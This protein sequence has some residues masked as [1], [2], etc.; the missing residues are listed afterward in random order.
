MMSAWSFMLLVCGII[1]VLMILMIVTFRKRE[2]FVDNRLIKSSAPSVIVKYSLKKKSRGVFAKRNFKEGDIIESAPVIELDT[3]IATHLDKL[4]DYVF[5]HSTKEKT[6]LVVFGYGSLY[7]HDDDNNIKYTHDDE[8]NS[9]L[10][11]A[12]RDIR[13]GEELCVSYGQKWWK[14]RPTMTK[15]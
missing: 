1:V 6:V 11:E 5:K 13:A 8:K 12:T 15:I 14:D 2:D 9:F 3:K 4:N 10:F 7:N